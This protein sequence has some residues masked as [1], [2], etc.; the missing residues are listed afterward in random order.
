VSHWT[1][2]SSL[3]FV[4]AHKVSSSLLSS[5][6]LHHDDT[7]SATNSHTPHGTHLGSNVFVYLICIRQDIGIFAVYISFRVEGFYR[8]I[9][10]IALFEVNM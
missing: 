7:R 1:A 10:I 5:E 2:N 3:A 6:Q 9:S 4:I 8:W